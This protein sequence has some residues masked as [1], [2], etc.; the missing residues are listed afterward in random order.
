MV[1]RFFLTLIV[2]ILLLALGGWILLQ[3]MDISAMDQ[4]SRTETF[5]AMHAK[6][7]LLA[8]EARQ[9]LPPQPAATADGIEEGHTT[10]GSSCA[11]CHGYDG[12]TPT[13]L[14]KSLY[15]QAPSLASPGPQSYTDGELFVAIRGGIRLSGMPAFGNSHSG[16]EIWE[17]VQYIR[18]LP[19]LP[20]HH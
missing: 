1:R 10:Y 2:L 13:P 6:H 15:P 11:G 19:K 4:P 3:R 12:R 18:T 9:Q 20:A 17:L 14:G 16:E 7:Y 5:L 8:R